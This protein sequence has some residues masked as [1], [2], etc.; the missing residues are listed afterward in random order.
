MLVVEVHCQ[1]KHF[2]RVI[3]SPRL[4]QRTAEVVQ[5]G[6]IVRRQPGRLR[7]LSQRFLPPPQFS[8]HHCQ[9]PPR[10]QK[11][12]MSCNGLLKQS[13]GLIPPPLLKPQQAKETQ[14]IR[15]SGRSL[16]ECQIGGFGLAEPP[17]AVELKRKTK[18]DARSRFHSAP[19]YDR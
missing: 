6:C 15:V 11:I 16:Q 13:H 14:Q 8:Q 12:R 7:M 17:G 3:Q 9:R 10:V 4:K 19:A 2:R 1:P 18:V 5:D